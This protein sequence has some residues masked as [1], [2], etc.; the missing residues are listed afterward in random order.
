MAAAESPSP[1]PGPLLR[2]LVPAPDEIEPLSLSRIAAEAGA[3]PWA[4]ADREMVLRIAYAVGDASVP[5]DFAC[6]DGAVQIGVEALQRGAPLI[7]DVRMV[8]VGIDRR[9]A[10]QL[11]VDVR[12][13]I[14]DPV[15]A[16]LAGKRGITRAAQAMLSQASALTGAVVVIGNAPTALLALLDMI[17]AGVTRPALILGF[18]VGYVAA[19]AAK[20]EL[21][22]RA[23]PFM[24]V[25]GP[26]GGTPMAVSAANTLLRLATRDLP[27]TVPRDGKSPVGPAAKRIQIVGIG[28]DGLAGLGERA[29][30]ALVAARTIYGGT[31][32]LEMVRDTPARKA[33]LSTGYQ[34]A[35]EELV[36]GRCGDDAVVL[37][38]GDP[39]LFGMGSTLARHFGAA[40]PDRIE[41]TPHPSSV[42][43]ALSRLGEPS[44]NVAVLSALARPLRPVLA[45]AM[46]LRRFAVLLDPE[47]HAA[48]VARA[49]LDAGMEDAEAVVCERLEG[50]DERIVRSTLSSIA[51][52][53]FDPL[54]LLVVLRSPKEVAR[55][56]RSAIPDQEFAH[57]AGQITKADVRALAVAALGLRPSDTLWD[58]GAGSGSVGIEAALGLPRGA[59]YAVDSSV[60]QIEFV[61]SNSVRFRTPHVE[62]VYGAAP[63][64][65]AD[66]PDPD[67]VF[68]GGGGRRLIGI[69]D[70]VLARLQPGGRIV[71]TL[72]TLERLGPVLDALKPWQPELRQIAIAH[73]VSLS[74]GTR[75]Q[76]ANPIWLVAATRPNAEG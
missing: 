55:Y 71:V 49:L 44:D 17:D 39:M 48:T 23:V 7:A 22:Q 50:T 73:G 56:R 33:N 27:A 57:R 4:G 51:A 74:D 69:L 45:A 59:V 61:R 10:R 5:K 76:P 9:R 54:S 11:G 52:A 47:H 18:P 29:R 8:V 42:Q 70:I 40:T 36:S 67:A 38:S 31:R 65:L 64:V 63:E 30:A 26:R 46:P 14:D 72:A 24:T 25:R 53:A 15:I 75:L 43:V 12:T 16:D 60:E 1:E 34:A 41:V 2:S 35:L 13:R 28:D 68:V 6:S 19:A 58:I 20:A 62:P 3:L 37:A 21:E 66:L 32:Q